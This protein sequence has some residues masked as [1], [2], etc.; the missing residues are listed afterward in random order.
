[1]IVHYKQLYKDFMINL[2]QQNQGV[3]ES[4]K[5]QMKFRKTLV[6]LSEKV[7]E[8]KKEKLDAKKVNLRR[9]VSTEGGP[10]DMRKMDPPRPCPILPNLMFKGIEP[11]KC[12]LFQSAMCPLKLDFYA[13]NKA[14]G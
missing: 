6:G 12:F 7:K 5:S 13:V 11:Q 1:M 4:L 10:F 2:Q 9:L 8:N 3:F 14:L